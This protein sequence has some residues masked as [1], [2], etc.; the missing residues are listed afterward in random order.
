MINITRGT[1]VVFVG[2]IC[3]GIQKPWGN[4]YKKMKISGFYILPSARKWGLEDSNLPIY[5][6][7]R[8]CFYEYL[9]T[10]QDLVLKD[11][12]Y[13]RHFSEIKIWTTHSLQ[14]C[15][16]GREPWGYRLLFDAKVVPIRDSFG[17][18]GCRGLPCEEFQDWALRWFCLEVLEAAGSGCRERVTWIYLVLLSMIHNPRLH[19]RVL[20][21]ARWHRK[22]GHNLKFQLN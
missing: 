18:N 10:A 16:S 20:S 8:V 5:F 9:L 14:T 3:I 21:G 13:Q 11:H 1:D 22:K 7:C 19:R 12:Q 4:S 17:L 15:V 2:P 6:D